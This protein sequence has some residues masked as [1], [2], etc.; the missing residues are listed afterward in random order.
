MPSNSQIINLA[1][2]GMYEDRIPQATQDNL[3]DVAEAILNYEPAKNAV[4]NEV[5]NKIA[6]TLIK[7]MKFTNPLEVF[8]KED[9]RF[10]ETVEELFV[11]LPTGYDP[12]TA[13]TDPFTKQ[14]PSVKA[15]YKSINS[16][17]QYEQT[18]TDYDFRRALRAEG[19]LTSLVNS[20][21][22]NMA[23]AGGTDDYLKLKQVI[24]DSG[25]YG[26]IV[27]MGAPTG[28]DTTDALTLLKAIKDNGSAM[29]F[30]SNRYNA[31]NVINT[32]MLEDQVLL[33]KNTW[34]NKINI[35][36]LTGY[37][38]LSKGEIEQR[39]IV[40]DDFNSADFVAVLCHK[41]FIDYRKSLQ[42]G[43]MIYNPKGVPYTNHYYNVYGLYS[44][45]LFMPAVAFSFS[46]A[47]TVAA[48]ITASDGSSDVTDFTVTDSTGKTYSL[49]G[50]VYNLVAEMY[51]VSKTG[52]QDYTFVV[53]NEQ[54][55]Q[56]QQLNINALMPVN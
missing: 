22:G 17:M 47:P 10:G 5:Y 37:F 24:S 18:I 3:A 34:Y 50:G 6:L 11:E 15:L 53:T 9:I 45:S 29:S 20:I 43:G 1:L 39:I 14:Q 4:L 2:G 51:T 35:D 36:L 33:I 56:G 44:V 55:K 28:T 38:N 25:A 8:R 40:V 23:I 54:V 48:A 13:T 52:Y 49:S 26:K 16:E 30:P 41:D 7:T 42:D 46:T 12:R 32:A 19:G 21:V 31:K 27:Y